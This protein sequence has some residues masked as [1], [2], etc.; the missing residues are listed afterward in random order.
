MYVSALG[1]WIY[2][3]VDTDKVTSAWENKNLKLRYKETK[4]T[5]NVKVSEKDGSHEYGTV[6]I[7]KGTPVT[8]FM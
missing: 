1:G 5:A 8:K 7:E 2:P 4:E 6:T 3:K